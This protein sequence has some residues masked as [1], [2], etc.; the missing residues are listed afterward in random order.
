MKRVLRFAPILALLLLLVG[1]NKGEHVHAFGEWKQASASTC[2]VAG[3]ET[4]RC[5]CGEE[6]RRAVAALGHSYVDD[7]CT[8]CDA[9]LDSN[10]LKLALHE[11][12]DR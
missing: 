1:C 8:E 7:R 12:G 9:V 5:K 6:E 3:E 2:T 10:A 11:D 4:R